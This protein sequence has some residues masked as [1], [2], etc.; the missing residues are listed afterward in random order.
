MDRK[1][2][3]RLRRKYADTHGGDVHDPRYRKV[4]ERIFSATGVRAKPYAGV[5]TLLDAPY[6][7]L[8]AAKPD[9]GA[10]QAALIGVPM[11]LG[12]T[13][14]PGA[15]FGPRALRTMERIGPYNHALDCAP[16]YDLAVADVGDVH[17]RS[18]YSL[19]RSLKDI[20]RY[21]AKVAAAEVAP[22]A[23]GGDHS[24][25]YPI[26]KALG[27]DRPLGMVHI[28]AHCD[29]G[30]TFDGAKFHHGGPFR[31]AVLAGA[32]DPKRTVQIGI[33]GSAEYLWE[34]S[35]DSGMTVLHIE[36]V[37]QMGIP[38]VVETARKVIGDG[39]VYV[40]FDVDGLDPVFAPGTGTPEVGGLTTR[41][42]QAILHGLKGLD[43]IGGDVV[44]VAPQY[45][46]TTAT[47]QAG[48]QML[49]EILGL[50][51]YSP[52]IGGR[53]AAGRG[54]SKTQTGSN[55]KAKRAAKRS[56]PKRKGRTRQ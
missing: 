44:E 31:H 5:P 52:S 53:T 3:Q 55:A 23:V 21:F 10:L 45:D 24:I 43:V 38:A 46:P 25:T 51:V 50:M 6:R 15:R 30:G 2:L 9:F 36:E 17:F 14:R 13:N 32:L 20:E 22:L 47:A 34:F 42:A 28:D 40:S 29:T 39:P 48:A 37:A 27:R 4:A 8:D 1:E 7:E 41:E 56:V 11:D 49:F 54:P 18:R 19:D 16:V 35:F 33:R 26:L 12:V